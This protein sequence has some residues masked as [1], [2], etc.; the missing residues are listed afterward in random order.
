MD[1]EY[2]PNKFKAAALLLLRCS[3]S[4]LAWGEFS[5]CYKNWLQIVRHYFGLPISKYKKERYSAAERLLWAYFMAAY[6]RGIAYSADRD[7]AD[8]S[9]AKE[10]V[11]FYLKVTLSYTS[12]FYSTTI[13]SGFD[14][15]TG[16]FV[17]FYYSCLDYTLN[18]WSPLFKFRVFFFFKIGDDGH[19]VFYS[20]IFTG[21]VNFFYF[22]SF[23]CS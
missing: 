5:I 22:T 16:V 7:I 18:N 19:Y 12:V 2:R 10:S 20:T 15:F 8:M 13:F 11:S 1:S 17:S 9:K 14:Y 6:S 23:E 21:I 3:P 4:S